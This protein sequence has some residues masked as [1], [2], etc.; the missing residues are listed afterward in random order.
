MEPCKI[1]SLR[2]STGNLQSLELQGPQFGKENTM[3]INNLPLKFSL[4]ENQLLPI[5]NLFPLLFGGN[6]WGGNPPF[7]DTPIFKREAE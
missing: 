6:N 3:A 7:S 4:S 5:R 1:L 2:F